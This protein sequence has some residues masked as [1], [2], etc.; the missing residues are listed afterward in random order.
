MGQTLFRK[1]L[2]LPVSSTDLPKVANLDLN[3]DALLWINFLIFLILTW[4]DLNITLGEFME[5]YKES[6]KVVKSVEGRK[7]LWTE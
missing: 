6:F 1:A 7:L 2:G 3:S 4:D 5:C